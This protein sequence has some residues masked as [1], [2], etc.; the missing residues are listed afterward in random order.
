[1]ERKVYA[2]KEERKDGKSFFKKTK[3][4]GENKK[5]KR[6]DDFKHKDGI[7]YG[8]KEAPRLKSF[9][10]HA[11]RRIENNKVCII[12]A[13]H[14]PT[15]SG[16][17]G[18][19]LL[20]SC[21]ETELKVSASDRN[22]Y[23]TQNSFTYGE[24]IEN[25]LT[26]PEFE[27]NKIWVAAINDIPEK[28]YGKNNYIVTTFNAV[29]PD[30]KQLIKLKQAKRVWVPSEKHVNACIKA[31]INKLNLK[32]FD[33]PVVESFNKMAVRPAELAKKKDVFRFLVC[34]S[35]TYKNGIEDVL[36]AYITEFKPKEKVELVI[37]LTHFPNLKKNLSFEIAELKKRLGALN[38]MFAKVTIVSHTLS[39]EGFAGLIASADAYVTAEK[40]SDSTLG[41]KEAMACN[42]AVIASK[43]LTDATKVNS[44]GIY[45]VE[46]EDEV[47]E[48]G[49]LFDSSSKQKVR[50][51]NY[52]KLAEVMRKAFNEKKRCETT[53]NTNCLKLATEI[54]EAIKSR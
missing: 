38:D 42:V 18:S 26:L 10:N 7:S 46:Y 3:P 2:H 41:I 50:K 13:F 43:W 14:S 54:K 16:R 34:G 40:V 8:K 35:P 45:P 25:I 44:E 23:L 47:I 11:V 1:M 31:G 51:I 9:S 4:F 20:R 5:F 17:V 12:A 15:F 48:P 30:S 6:K 24:D 19:E 21:K 33:I 28:I 39:D 32:V 53:W 29:N 52:E 27:E 36:K 22:T 49:K 37:K